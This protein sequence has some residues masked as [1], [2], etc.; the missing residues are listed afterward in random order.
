MRVAM[1]KLPVCTF[2]NFNVSQGANLFKIRFDVAP[3]V[4][5][6][7][8]WGKLLSSDKTTLKFKTFPGNALPCGAYAFGF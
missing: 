5:E 1:L 2:L 3:Y 7:W 6:R 8:F 4:L